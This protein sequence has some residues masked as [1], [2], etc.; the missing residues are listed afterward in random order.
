MDSGMR[1]NDDTII[2]SRK[3]AEAFGSVGIG[4]V[5]RE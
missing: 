1:W 4:K 5:K 3:K 2:G